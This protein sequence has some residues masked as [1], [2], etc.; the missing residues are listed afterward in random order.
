MDIQRKTKVE[1]IRP[2]AF[3]LLGHS[4]QLDDDNKRRDFQVLRMSLKNV[5]V[6]LYDELLKR[7]KNQ[8]G[9]VYTD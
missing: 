1:V 3:V 6:I 2:R 8:K 7:I 9:K 4:D 5:E